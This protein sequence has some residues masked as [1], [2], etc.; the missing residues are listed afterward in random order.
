MLLQKVFYNSPLVAFQK[1]ILNIDFT[2]CLN[3]IGGIYFTF[4]KIVFFWKLKRFS[5]GLKYDFIL[6][7]VIQQVFEGMGI[8]V[9]MK[10]ACK[11]SLVSVRDV[12][13]CLLAVQNV[14]FYLQ[15][16]S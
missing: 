12:F 14:N 7:N 10:H 15:N 6:L 1:K 9:W 13:C 16:C 5:A 8:L 2:F 3:W 4:C 11:L